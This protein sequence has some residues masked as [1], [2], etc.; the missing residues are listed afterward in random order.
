MGSSKRKDL[1]NAEDSDE[2]GNNEF[3]TKLICILGPFSLALR[4]RSRTV[5]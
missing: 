5:D 3:K 4:Y 2:G 1:G